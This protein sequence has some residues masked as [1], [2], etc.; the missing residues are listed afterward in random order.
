[1]KSAHAALAALAA[2]A[3]P[4]APALAGAYVG[5][6]MTVA[7]T[8]CPQNTLPANGALLQPAQYPALYKLI[9]TSFGGT[10]GTDFALPNVPPAATVQGPPLT[11][12]I[13][14]SGITPPTA[15]RARK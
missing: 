12:C 7:W 14:V 1:M 2:L 15:A 13:T 8:F 9:G 11:Y 10:P 5:E 3:L 4:A 6:V